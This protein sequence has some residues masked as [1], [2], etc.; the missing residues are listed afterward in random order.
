MGL[1]RLMLAFGVLLSHM[2]QKILTPLGLIGDFRLS[3]SL[4]GG[5]AVIFSMSSGGS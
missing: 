4:Q 3:M 1:I 2:D 5:V